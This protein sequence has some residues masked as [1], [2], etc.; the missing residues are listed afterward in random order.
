MP[1]VVKL[2]FF[3]TKA[4]TEKVNFDAHMMNLTMEDFC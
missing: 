4:L 1:N 2:F 3:I